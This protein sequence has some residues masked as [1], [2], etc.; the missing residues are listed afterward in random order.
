MSNTRGRAGVFKRRA[1]AITLNGALLEVFLQLWSWK[2]RVSGEKKKR[3]M[4]CCGEEKARMEVFEL[5]GD[6]EG[7]A[8]TTKRAKTSTGI[9]ATV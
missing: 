4:T 1:T 2:L 9:V 5:I 7:L 3:Q 8:G 6:K